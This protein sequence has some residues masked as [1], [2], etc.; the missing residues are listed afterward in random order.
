[1]SQ[2]NTKKNP[3][4]RDV[5]MFAIDKKGKHY[6]AAVVLRLQGNLPFKPKPKNPDDGGMTSLLSGASPIIID[7]GIGTGMGTGTGGIGKPRVTPPA[8]CCKGDA[9]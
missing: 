3:V 5:V 7:M 9:G 6:L 1:M 2:M 4:K 8:F